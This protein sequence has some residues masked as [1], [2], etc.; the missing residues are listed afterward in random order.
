[1]KILFTA[2]H[3]YNGIELACVQEVITRQIYII[4]SSALELKKDVKEKTFLDR[5]CRQELT[6]LEE[7]AKGNGC[8]KRECFT[9]ILSKF[10]EPNCKKLANDLLLKL[11]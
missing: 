6:F 2:E 8:A 10:P 1:M 5:L 3:E 7:V 11:Q 4:D 9:C